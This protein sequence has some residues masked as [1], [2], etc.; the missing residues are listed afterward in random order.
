MIDLHSHIL[1]SID[2]G[3]RSVDES[4]QMLKELFLQGITTVVATPHFNANH[5]SVNDF[6]KKREESFINLSAN[7]E[8]YMPKILL[9]AEVKYYEGISRLQC[10]DKLKIENSKILLLEMPM[11]KW[12]E[13]VLRELFE[14]SS[15]G[16]LIIV[17]AHIER[18]LSFQGP[19]I[20]QNLV[21]H[22]IYIQSNADFFIDFYS[23][24]KAVRMLSNNQIHFI[25]SDCHDLVRRP[26]K[27][28]SAIQYICR[29][30]GER[31]V[32]EMNKF[33]YSF[34]DM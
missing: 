2:D 11:V 34:F 4:I 28:S 18:Y 7:I 23:R 12:S 30:K 13:Y 14:F 24:R 19:D 16:D 15:R 10:L 31:F 17:L 25:G 21:E 33:N 1:P 26:P 3:S 5:N 29:K 8:S 9:G 6:L 27:I 22:G 20:V 32:S